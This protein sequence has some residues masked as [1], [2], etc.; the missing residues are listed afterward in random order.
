MRQIGDVIELGR[1]DSLQLHW[2]EDGI[3]QQYHFLER[4]FCG[5]ILSHHDNKRYYNKNS[6]RCMKIGT[7]VKEIIWEQTWETAWHRVGKIE[8]VN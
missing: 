1:Q 3:G 6:W 2:L 7:F 4:P 5:K 8:T